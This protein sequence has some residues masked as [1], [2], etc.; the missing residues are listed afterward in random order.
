[1]NN[2]NMQG[3]GTEHRLERSEGCVGTSSFVQRKRHCDSA[4][5]QVAGVY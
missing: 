3:D 4:I 2:A 5:H 1:M